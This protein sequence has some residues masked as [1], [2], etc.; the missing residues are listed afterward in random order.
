MKNKAIAIDLGASNLR[1]AII[2]RNGT[3]VTEQEIKTPQKKT[4]KEFLKEITFLIKKTIKN[5]KNI[6]GIGVSSAGPLDYK[7]GIILNPANLPYK[8]ISLKNYL[9]KA[10]SLPVFL[11]NDCTCGALGEKIFGRGKSYS[12]F[13]YITISSGIGCGVIV[14]NRVLIGKDGN[15]GEIG[16]YVVD[17]TYNLPCKCKRGKGHWESYCSGNNIPGFLKH[18]LNFHKIEKKY[19]VK[20]TK[21]LFL[22]AEKRDKILL[23]FIKE[24]GEINTRGIAN[25]VAS[26]NPEIIFFGG[27]TF[28]N[29]KKFILPYFD[30]KRFISSAKLE[31]A[32][33]KEKAPLMGAASL[34]FYPLSFE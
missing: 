31:T 6:K 32:S 27:A 24:L 4:E 11:Q 17:S 9:S 21:D 10:F 28:L 29:H 13:L 23:K 1:V 14:D 30:K 18:W 7:K 19:N 16:H 25:A 33:L 26:F 8:R 3:V 20:K 12:N 5:E 34:V 15:I 22:L 2:R